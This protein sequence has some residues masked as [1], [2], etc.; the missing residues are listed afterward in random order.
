MIM[1]NAIIADNRKI[2]II[3]NNKVIGKCRSTYIS[4]YPAV[5]IQQLKG[6]MS[7]VVASTSASHLS[8][9]HLTIFFNS[10]T[11]HYLCSGISGVAAVEI[12]RLFKDVRIVDKVN[13]QTGLCPDSFKDVEGY[14]SHLGKS[15]AGST[16]KEK[17]M[18]YKEFY[19]AMEVDK[20]ENNFRG[21]YP[22]YGSAKV[23]SATCTEFGKVIAVWIRNK[24]I[25]WQRSQH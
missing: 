11:G 13:F 17:K 18:S 1:N 19:D 6:D 25:V 9:S 21:V 14:A 22:Q 2:L 24:G 5:R 20:N 3:E 10:N 16:N 23:I 8:V 4:G 12:D 7:N 15:N